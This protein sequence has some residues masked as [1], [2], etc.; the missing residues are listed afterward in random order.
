M[1]ADYLWIMFLVITSA[2]GFAYA[3]DDCRLVEYPDHY[4]AVCEGD[5]K[6]V[7]PQQKE[8]AK[9]DIKPVTAVV[10]NGER[11]PP[12]AA[13]EN[14][15]AARRKLIRELRQTDLETNAPST[16]TS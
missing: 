7:P 11:R 8:D 1:K 4:E 15:A 10:V 5:A 16:G 14:A 3:K 6:Y 9:Q 2:P 12:R 13:M